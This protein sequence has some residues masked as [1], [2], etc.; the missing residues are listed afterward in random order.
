MNL[1]Y[2]SKYS[3]TNVVPN[4]YNNKKEELTKFDVLCSVC[5]RS[6][7]RSFVAIKII[8]YSLNNN[9]NK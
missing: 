9:Y 2:S 5:V 3:T 7:V 4:Q 6:F 1:E 8:F